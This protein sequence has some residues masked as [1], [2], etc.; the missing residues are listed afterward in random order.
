MQRHV[1]LFFLLSYRAAVR[2]KSDGER[3]GDPSAAARGHG[4]CLRQ[5]HV[6]ELCPDGG[7]R[8]GSALGAVQ[9]GPQSDFAG[10]HGG[11]RPEPSALEYPQETT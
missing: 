4:G 3:S 10:Q 2:P 1:R 8:G 6:R 9:P 11:L 5:S 7:E